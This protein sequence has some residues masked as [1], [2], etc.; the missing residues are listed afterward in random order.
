MMWKMQIDLHPDSGSLGMTLSHAPDFVKVVVHPEDSSDWIWDEVDGP[1]KI[2]A[3]I[4]A[5]MEKQ[6]DFLRD[7]LKVAFTDQFKFIYPG[8]GQL[9]FGDTY[10]N[11]KG[12]LLAVIDYGEYVLVMPT[13]IAFHSV[14]CVICTD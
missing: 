3:S 14:N 9:K 8:N 7:T 10:F 6:L 2:Q 5:S 4:Q 12:D 11:N 1:K 13:N